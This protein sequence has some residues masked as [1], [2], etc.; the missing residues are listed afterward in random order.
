MTLAGSREGPE[1]RR[2]VPRYAPPL[3][4]LVGDQGK[5]PSRI[6]G[7]LEIGAVIVV[8]PDIEAVRRWLPS[9]LLGGQKPE[10]PHI[11]VRV[12]QL[13]IDL[14]ERQVRW[15]DR[16][17]DLSDHELRLLAALAEYPGRVWGRRRG[18]PLSW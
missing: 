5:D 1:A 4:V 18:W 7:L 11:I 15:L 16:V 10:L 14:T 13:E 8:A 9:A 12:S 3:I 17:L 2:G 6:T